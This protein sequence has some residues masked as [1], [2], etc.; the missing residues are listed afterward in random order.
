MDRS[1][2]NPFQEAERGKNQTK[3]D[4][5]QL[6]SC[7]DGV[8]FG[9]SVVFGTTSPGLECGGKE[10]NN[11][12]GSIWWC[13]R[14]NYQ[15]ECPVLG[16]GIFT[17]NAQIC[18][19]YTFW[20]GKQCE[21]E[22]RERCRAGNR[23]QC[24]NKPQWGVEYLDGLDVTCKDGSDKYRPI[25]KEKNEQIKEMW[26]TEPRT[27]GQYNGFGWK[28]LRTPEERAKYRKDSTTGLW[29]IAVTEETCK[30]NQGFACKVTVFC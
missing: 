8:G 22:S 24:V 7:S 5:S 6:K 10:S 26:K 14:D 1:D 12:L 29:M 23:G 3:I 13:R 19:N 20:Q 2:E 11:C 16:E 15:K 30:A 17:T 28:A 18:Q 4:F 21:S 25:I 9:G 27:E